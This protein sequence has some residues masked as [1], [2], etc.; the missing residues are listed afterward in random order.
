MVKNHL[1]VWRNM[2]NIYINNM[3]LGVSSG[4]NISRP[5]EFFIQNPMYGTWFAEKGNAVAEKDKDDTE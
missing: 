3:L 4:R 5:H 1:T 2:K